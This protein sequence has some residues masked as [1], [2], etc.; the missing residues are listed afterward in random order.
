M[1]SALSDTLAVIRSYAGDH[2]SV[3]MGS[4]AFARRHRAVG[5]PDVRG[6]DLR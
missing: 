4:V 5:D 6:I 2:V 3:C 1:H